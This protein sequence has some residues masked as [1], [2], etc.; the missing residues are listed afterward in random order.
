[1]LSMNG[2]L[3]FLLY[4]SLT[5]VPLFLIV[6]KLKG[7]HARFSLL[8]FIPHS[9]FVFMLWRLPAVMFTEP[10]TDKFMI[11]LS[12]L[13]VV[14]GRLPYSILSLFAAASGYWAWTNDFLRIRKFF[15]VPAPE[16]SVLESPLE[17]EERGFE[18]PLE[19][20][21][22]PVQ[23]LLDMGVSLAD[24][25]AALEA[26]GGDLNRAAAMLFT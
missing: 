17:P 19:R 11:S 15:T 23:A 14:I 5:Y 18:P 9:L 8:G 16:I 2:F 7:F 26:Q 3:A 24:A 22:D 12:M 10:L 4:N 20:T 1:M 6:L 13:L 25:R 21:D